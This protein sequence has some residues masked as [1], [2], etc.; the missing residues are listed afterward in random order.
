MTHETRIKVRKALD[1]TFSRKPIKG[2]PA[3]R[4]RLIE[5]MINQRAARLL[6]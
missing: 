5:E 6:E 4:L 1:F 2:F 3:K